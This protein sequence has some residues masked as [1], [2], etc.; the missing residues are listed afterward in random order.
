M[1]EIPALIDETTLLG[2]IRLG[3]SSGADQIH[4]RAG[5]LPLYTWHDD[6]RQLH[7]RQLTAEDTERIAG[8]LLER[9]LVPERVCADPADAAHAL[10]LFFELPGEELLEVNVA[11]ERSALS[12]AVEIVRPL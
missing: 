5:C 10:E 2:A 3:I 7:Y 11:R 1:Q 4:F 12:V 6:A 9:A 8:M